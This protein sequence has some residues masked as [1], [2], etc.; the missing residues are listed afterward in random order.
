MSAE[1]LRSF[2]IFY[3][4]YLVTSLVLLESVLR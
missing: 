4:I 1:P 3:F 2:E